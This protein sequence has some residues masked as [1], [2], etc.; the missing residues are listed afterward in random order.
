MSESLPNPPYKT[1]MI[2][3]SGFL[4]PAWNKF[5]FQVFKR[6]GGNVALSN[7]ELAGLTNT[8]TDQI[9]L[10]QTD[11]TNIETAL[12]TASNDFNQGPVL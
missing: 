7:L 10:I 5:I 1:P 9:V 12:A 2:D 3:Q 4:T 6:A 11:L 8:F